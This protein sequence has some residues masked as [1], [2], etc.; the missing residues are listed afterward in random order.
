MESKDDTLVYHI[1]R[2]WRDAGLDARDTAM[3]EYVEKLTRT[4]GQVNQED[5]DKLRAEGFDDRQMLDIVLICAMFNFMTRIADGT[6]T[7]AEESWRANKQ[8]KDAAVKAELEAELGQ[9]A[10][11]A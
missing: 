2:D 8:R 10:A 11:Q 1:A 7:R 5:V 6:G 9:R 3:L 4:P